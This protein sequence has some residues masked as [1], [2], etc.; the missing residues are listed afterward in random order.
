CSSRQLPD[1]RTRS[2]P[3]SGC[4]K[5]TPHSGPPATLAGPARRPSLMVSPGHRPRRGRGSRPGPG[6]REAG[7]SRAASGA[8]TGTPKR[9]CHAPPDRVNTQANTWGSSLRAS[10]S[11]R[12]SSGALP[13]PHE[14]LDDQPAAVALLELVLELRGALAHADL[15]ISRGVR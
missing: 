2:V 9:S 14:G 7:G 3:A 10:R 1:S 5:V 4:S 13:P 12:G 15:P 8:T 6:S 11:R